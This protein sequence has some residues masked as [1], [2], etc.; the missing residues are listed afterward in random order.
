MLLGSFHKSNINILTNKI[1]WLYTMNNL[2]SQISHQEAGELLLLIS[3]AKRSI[4]GL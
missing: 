2:T 3:L 1:H 4:Q